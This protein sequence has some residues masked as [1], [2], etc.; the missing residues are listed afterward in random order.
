[1]NVRTPPL[2]A[3]SA[4]KLALMAK[5]VRVQAEEVMRADPIAIIGMACRV[6]G[7]GDTPTLFWQVLR[8][9]VCAIREVPA[10]RW[11][12]N[13]WYDPDPA[14]VAKSA[15][16]WGG[17]LDRVDEFDADYFGI[18]PREAERMD[19]QQRLFLEVAIEAIDDA[20][21][22][23]E[24]LRGSRTGVYVASYHND[25]AQLQNSDL[26][27]IDPRTLTGTLHSVL[28]NRLSYF[29]D[30]RGPS[31][32]IDTACSSSLVAIHTAC[33]S[34]RFGETN[35]A[36]AGGVS[37][38][39][40]PQLMVSMSKLGFMAP[41]G[42]CKTFDERADGF[43]RGEG[44]AIVVLKRLSDAIADSDRI[45][46][47]IRGSAVNQDGHST[48]L[49]APNGP[50]QQALI[51]EA[52]ACAQV[53]PERIGFF[54][55][56][57]TGTA[58]GDPIE[59]EAI[60]A[61]IGRPAA[62]VGVCLL[63]SAKANVGHLE[64]AAGVTGLVK[65]VLALVHE[66]A[67]PQVNFS[68]LN[69]HIVL[70]GTRLSIPQSLVPW[71]AGPTPR[72]AAISSF[73]V[74][75]TNANVIIEEAPRLAAAPVEEGSSVCRVLPLS[76]QDPAALRALAHSWIRFLAE[77]SATIADL[78]HTASLRRTHYRHRIALVGRSKEEL[79]A[80]LRDSLGCTME[81][82]VGRPANAASPRVGF[83]FSG[84]GPQ[85]HAMGRELLVE[86][87]V[88]RDVMS[89]CDA[90]LGALSGWSILE[91]LA[92]P[93]ERSRLDQTEIAQPALFALQ[94][95]LAAL[96]KSWG[97]SCDAVVGHS[98]GEIA[99]LHVA[100]ALDLREAVRLVWHRGRIMQQ[101]TGLGRM[102][103]VALSEAKAS[104]LQ[105]FYGDRLA[106]GAVNSPRSAVLSGEAA[107]L[108]EALAKLAAGGVSHRMLPVQYAFHSA[109]M[110]PFRDQLVEQLGGVRAAAPSVD[111]YSTVTGGL[112]NHVCFDRFYFGRN[113]RDQVRFASA[114]R[115]MADDGCDLFIE[116]GP[117]PVLSASIAECLE[118]QVRV[119]TVLAS[120]RHG[121]PER[122]TMLQACADAYAA[123][124]DLNWAQAQPTTGL[125]VELPGYPWQ[126]KRHWIRASS[127]RAAVLPSEAHPFLGRQI[128][129]AGIEAEIFEASPERARAW[130]VDHRIFDKLLLPAAAVIE[131]FAAAAGKALG[132][133]HRQLTGF[134]IR[135]PVIISEAGEG[136]THWQV[137]VRSAGTGR[138]ELELHEAILGPEGDVSG[139]RR[140][141]SA[142]A[143]PATPAAIFEEPT[144][145]GSKISADALYAKFK[146]L[147][148][149][150]GPA[151]RCLR[152]IE[153]GDG[154]AR[155]RIELPE[156]VE[157][158][159]LHDA[160]H[161][162]LIDAG[163]QLCLLAALSGADSALPD[164]LFLPLG[165][166]RIVINP[167][168]G[169]VFRGL[170]RARQATSDAT[171]VAD[172][173]LETEEG[174]LAMFAEG[175]RFARA[176]PGALAVAG[177]SDGLLYDIAW[178]RAPELPVSGRANAEGMWLLF[179]DRGGT[180]DAL[181]A[182]IEAAGGRCCRVLAGDAF[183]RMS[184]RS[185]TIDPAEPEHFVRLLQ[186]GGWRGPDS[187]RGIVH[188]WTLDVAAF[189]GDSRRDAVAPD[190]L[191]PGAVLHLMQSLATTPALDANSLWLV[192]R[193]AQTISGAEPV[194]GLRPRAAGLWGLAGVIAIEHPELK[195]R[196]VDLDPCDLW[197]GA[198]GL[199]PELLASANPRVAL[200]G[201][202]RWLPGLR[203]Y[204]G[205][206]SAPEA[207]RDGRPLGFEL[208][209]P[210]AF[211]GLEL[212][213][214]P[215]APLRPD[216]V[217]LRVLAAGLNFR[218]VLLT[219]GMYPGAAVPLG[220]ECAGVVTEVGAA[221]AEF[222]VGDHV[223][224]LAP[225]SLATEATAPAAFLAPLPKGMRMED[226][227]GLPVAFLTAHYG[228]HRLAQLRAGERVLI[229]AAAGGVGL[230]A[231]QLAQRH[232][233]DVFATAGSP[234][235]RELLR[236][237]GVR[238][239][240]DSRSL[241]FADRI[242]EATDGEGVHVVLNSLAGDFIPAG[243]RSL[244]YG[245]RFLE[246]GKRDIWSSEAVANI[247][248]DVSYHPYDLGAEA[249][250]NCGV[251]R[252]M[253]QDILGAL[254]EGS[255]RSLP[256]TVFPRDGL[257]DAMRFMA[258]ARHV[259]KIVARMGADTGSGA[260][261]PLS[262]ES[263]ATY[264]ITG[265]L[266]AL[267][268]ETARWL[269]G[270]GARHLVLSARRPLN[271]A[272]KACVRKLEELG[273]TV[274]VFQADAADRDRMQFVFHEIC[275]SL[276]PLRG[277]VHAAGAIHDAVLI[278]QRW[279]EAREL[280]R[281][282]VDGAWVLHELTRD[283]PLEFF[284]LYSAAGVFLGASGQGMYPAA[285][286][287]LDA[288]AHAR[289]RLGL[290]ALSVA[291]G[292]WAGAGMADDLAARGADVWQARG[293]GKIDPA[294]AFTQLERL[295]ADGVAY[296][297]VIPV[298]WA[299]FLARLPAGAD[300]AFFDAVAPSQSFMPAAG[301]TSRDS[302]ISERLR[303]LPS[304][305]R[306]QEL[307]AHLTER[308][309][310]VLALDPAT[311]IEARVPLKEIGLDS[312]MAVE[313]RNSLVRSGGQS[314]PATLLFD[315]PSLEALAA[316]LS[317]AWR[318]ETDTA[319]PAGAA[320]ATPAEF[321]DSIADLSDAEAEALL[322][323][324]LQ[325]S[326][327][328]SGA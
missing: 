144:T 321:V 177:D 136:R 323:E 220:A 295:L 152:E 292:P 142:A 60:A 247:R 25:Y 138:A 214:R 224:G 174:A 291:W 122:E 256:V 55:A 46:A 282:K 193:G 149:E 288:L 99:A 169:R 102:A 61:T 175:V 67:P 158:A 237:L 113:L 10:D 58:L 257:S 148:A 50:A 293:L 305:Q 307:I 145:P 272:A 223:F 116:I 185:W 15:T 71:P 216:Y 244:A 31:M 16:K 140:I 263:A 44:S 105:Q 21:L 95:A 199:L 165:A 9:G 155:A 254:A 154:F 227:A 41:D 285:N 209:H 253:L 170:A 178:R 78:C 315:Y 194:E 146:D 143:E 64:A 290:P 63:G 51:R 308:A 74:G 213:P 181:A 164:D 187:L 301:R 198:T 298:Q 29:L 32:S 274:S 139:W 133:S 262:R 77:T 91:E 312:L 57:G 221:V 215:T 80:R 39:I 195:V 76:A 207:S 230:A 184:D 271:V 106:V 82:G 54:E 235:K 52:L 120:L 276:P 204:A 319:H 72:C 210:G 267:G 163:V 197:A 150:F 249:E 2:A 13:A 79:A 261:V 268:L 196:V 43:G 186:Q 245:G 20:G 126:R 218:D 128:E 325:L 326:A 135:R 217:R 110:A 270:R 81:G 296:G 203:R 239:V 280:L 166:D 151:F 121:R 275:R 233:A 248:P 225:A 89:E 137:V 250:A 119:P 168:G 328:G 30:L 70:A 238:H 311:P 173:R 53:E 200:R 317:R 234:A 6:P 37:L 208:A 3:H 171:L 160:L 90:L 286:A 255:L 205:P 69:P 228:L 75:G 130:L 189:G 114:V 299:R 100:G 309:L 86:E 287:E 265:G 201:A 96:W 283:I 26:E 18:L 241:G 313:L 38:M 281:G 19:P 87:P 202:R 112:A 277:V 103:S 12:G 242:L 259:G 108:E 92:R 129:A 176:E 318:L 183:E 115:A 83:V 260:S 131:L 59:I 7:G 111:V 24:Q 157:R 179:A 240:M 118:A 127:A 229:H 11:D 190:L 159:A 40:T 147:G 35:L 101:A 4:I 316:F 94:V 85:W 109:Q 88:F 191:G 28:A 310:H 246:L 107:A 182:E 273:A 162:V 1:M 222:R 73:G 226:A 62:G 45:L 264:W 34:L 104:E 132:L 269:V 156:V 192:T 306:K 258:Q 125:V 5:Q 320:T 124:C 84:Q 49:A 231:A 180:A 48:L 153:R 219:L 42:R 236:S 297:A 22:P 266:G 322:L 303:A 232:G 206:E 302:I 23:H 14:A 278:N 212:R 300:R 251:V 279:T 93:K 47:V 327:I 27:A 314:L 304:G 117:Q 167:D 98:L 284:V 65:A 33:Q 161:P 134:A 17:F 188:C 68:K 211:D 66:A 289:R 123:G 324:E 97:V 8:D 36:I 243:I 141:A 56:H 252:P 294:V 172:V